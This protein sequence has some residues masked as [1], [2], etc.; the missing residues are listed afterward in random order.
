M[1]LASTVLRE[2]T[3]GILKK[4]AAKLLLDYMGKEKAHLR[5]DLLQNRQSEI[6]GGIR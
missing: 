1:K 5:L 4:M 2:E 3:D 6:G